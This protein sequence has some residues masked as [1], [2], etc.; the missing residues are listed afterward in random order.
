MNLKAVMRFVDSGN[1]TDINR[2]I[3]MKNK[4]VDRGHKAS[5]KGMDI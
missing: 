4:K 3:D 2:R 1:G 5:G